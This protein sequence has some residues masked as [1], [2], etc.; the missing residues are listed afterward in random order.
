[1]ENL[2][3]NS[4]FRVINPKES[5]NRRISRPLQRGGQTLRF[6]PVTKYKRSKLPGCGILVCPVLT[7]SG[8]P[9]SVTDLFTPWTTKVVLVPLSRGQTL[10]LT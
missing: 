4:N 1:M 7:V 10:R 5:V 8:R 3:N 2:I 9:D 6:I